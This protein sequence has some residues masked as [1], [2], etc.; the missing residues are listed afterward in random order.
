[1]IVRLSCFAL[2][3]TI[4]APV[5]AQTSIAVPEPSDA[6]L[7]VLAIVGLVVGRHS[8]RRRPGGDA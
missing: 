6:A 1:M 4:A 7:F 3:A 2:I 5:L 8:S